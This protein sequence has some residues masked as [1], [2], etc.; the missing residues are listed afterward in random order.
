MHIHHNRDA[1]SILENMNGLIAVLVVNTRIKKLWETIFFSISQNDSGDFFTSHCTTARSSRNQS[2]QLE[3]ETP[4]SKQSGTQSVAAC[5]SGC[6]ITLTTIQRTHR[7]VGR[8]GCMFSFFKQLT[9][10]LYQKLLYQ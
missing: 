7:P 6:V 3:R 10:K 9:A 8:E 2:Y 5:S 4:I 1:V